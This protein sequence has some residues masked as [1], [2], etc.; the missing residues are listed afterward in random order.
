M[1]KIIAVALAA[2][3]LNAS[4]WT[5][6]GNDKI[7]AVRAYLKVTEAGQG[8]AKELE[9]YGWFVGVVSGLSS[10]FAEH[11]YFSAICYPEG[12]NV[13]QLADIAAKYIVDHPEKRA[14]SLG[15]L[16]LRA[17][18]KAFGLQMVE[19][20]GEHDEWLQYNS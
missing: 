16:V 6:N 12:A 2:F 5:G 13:E 14:D 15:L 19:S 18:L 4:A 7:D 9:G 1:K 3:A 17:H 20:C 10:V 11:S 8:S